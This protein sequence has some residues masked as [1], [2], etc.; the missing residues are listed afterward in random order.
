MRPSPS[1]HFIHLSNM[2]C[3]P[4]ATGT[5][6]T[7]E[8]LF[9]DLKCDKLLMKWGMEMLNLFVLEYASNAKIPTVVKTATEQDLIATRDWQTVWTTPYAKQLPNKVALHRKDNDELLGLMSYELDEDGL[10]VE[11]LYLEN[12]RHSNANLLH[13][14]GGSKKYVGI[15]KALFAYAIQISLDAGFDGVL[16]FKAKTSELLSYYME[17]FGA[18]QVASYDPYRLVIWE[19]AAEDILSTFTMEVRD[20][21]SE[22]AG[23]SPAHRRSRRPDRVGRAAYTGG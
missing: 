15:A 19:D 21:G 10:A 14:E 3:S 7:G 12:A 9:F 4:T 2:Y 1:Y 8:L 6:N 16:I 5:L 11:I 13:S 20:N 22:R 18:R 23:I 17:K